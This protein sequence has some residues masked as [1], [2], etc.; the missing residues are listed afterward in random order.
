MMAAMNQTPNTVPD[1]WLTEVEAIAYLKL[2]GMKGDAKERMRN[3]IRRKG[4][5]YYELARGLRQYRRTELEA[6]R[7]EQRQ[8]PRSSDL[9]RQVGR[10]GLAAS[11][12]TRATR[13]GLESS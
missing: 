9:G 11:G 8:G 12:A 5:P 13:I 2:D 1:D 4:L 6:W 3:L 10:Q 7:N